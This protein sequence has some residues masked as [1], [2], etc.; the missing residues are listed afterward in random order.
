D[1]RGPNGSDPDSP[2]AGRRLRASSRPRFRGDTAASDG[3]ST[4][5]PESDQSHTSSSG[6]HRSSADRP[7]PTRSDDRASTDRQGGA[8]TRAR[9]AKPTNS[10]SSSSG[11]PAGSS[12]GS[13][14]SAKAPTPRPVAPRTRREARMLRAAAASGAS[15]AGVAAAASSN[16]PRDERSD[17]PQTSADSA[18]H[19][20]PRTFTDQ[21]TAASAG[22][23]TD[24][25]DAGPPTRR[26]APQRRAAQERARGRSRKRDRQ[27]NEEQRADAHEPA[28]ARRH[29]SRLGETFPSLVGWTSLSTLLPGVGLLRTRFR[30][31]GLV[32]FGLFVLTLLTGAVYLLGKGPVRAVATIVSRP[33]L[34]NFL[35]IGAVLVA[36][37]WILVM[38]VSHLGLRRGHRYRPWQTRWRDS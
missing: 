17:R 24:G 2:A 25:E 29:S 38:V 19:T 10:D 16:T 23:P 30:P 34:L 36:V 3:D 28:R 20:T 18:G 33:T 13:P 37:I 1:K 8:Y 7:R 22:R 32:V 12:S 15:A 4:T 6:Q 31:V 35:A 21:G 26:A 9:P 27:R 14:D 5:P 11:S